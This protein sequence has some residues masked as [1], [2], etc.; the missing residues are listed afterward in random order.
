MKVW[1]K[2]NTVVQDLDFDVTERRKY[3]C[4]PTGR[5]EF[6]TLDDQ[7]KFIAYAKAFFQKE[8]NYARELQAI[9]QMYG[10]MKP[11]LHMEFEF[12]LPEMPNA[13]TQAA[14]EEARNG[15]LPVHLGVPELMKELNKPE[16]KFKRSIFK[17]LF[18]VIGL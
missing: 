18:E 6:N 10:W 17:L 14:M 2:Q 3:L 13:E 5:V 12:D 9:G 4:Q 8:Q 11:Y 7:A 1:Q 16:P 15:H